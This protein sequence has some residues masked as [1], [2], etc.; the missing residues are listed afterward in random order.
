[1]ACG[2]PV[3]AARVGGL[4]ST[5]TDGETGY[6]VPWHCPEPYAERLE[7]LLANDHLRERLGVSARE[8]V[9]GMTWPFVVDRLQEVYERALGSGARELATAGC[10]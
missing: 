3:I 9:K 10:A 5:V 4:E 1:M 6:L 7:T 8:S 2:T